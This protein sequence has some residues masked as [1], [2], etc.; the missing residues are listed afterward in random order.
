MIGNHNVDIDLQPD[1]T[2]SSENLSLYLGWPGY[3]TRPGCSGYDYIDTQNEIAHM[4]GV[5]IRQLITRTWLHM[6][7]GPHPLVTL[8]MGIALLFCFLVP[9]IVEIGA[10]ILL[11]IANIAGLG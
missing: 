9:K 8:L 6:E 10:Y 7:S 11:V 3:R 1:T 4:T 5:F 2:V